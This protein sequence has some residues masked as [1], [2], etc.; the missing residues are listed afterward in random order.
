MMSWM[1]SGRCEATRSTTLPLSNLAIAGDQ[2]L[3]IGQQAGVKIAL[4][5][6]GIE[7]GET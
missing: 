3:R 4:L 1:F 6:E 2:D 7:T 5:H